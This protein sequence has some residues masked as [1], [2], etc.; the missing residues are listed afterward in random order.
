MA[1]L[2]TYNHIRKIY[3]NLLWRNGDQE[4]LRM[5]IHTPDGM[6]V[7]VNT[8]KV[9]T[10]K[11]HIVNMLINN[12]SL[13]LMRSQGDKGVPWFV[14]NVGYD[15]IVLGGIDYARMIYIIGVAAGCVSVWQRAV[16]GMSCPVTYVVLEDIRLRRE[17]RLR[18]SV[19]RRKNA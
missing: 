16:D 12:L 3:E 15:G 7:N 11:V 8:R 14:I 18:M 10:H 1:N 19:R 5:S 4:C 9:A 17:E 13:D 6:Q 2:F